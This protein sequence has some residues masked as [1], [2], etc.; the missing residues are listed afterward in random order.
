MIPHNF[1][2]THPP[3]SNP[4]TMGIAPVQQVQSLER[5]RHSLLQVGRYQNE[6]KSAPLYGIGLE[7]GA[8]LPRENGDCKKL[9]MVRFS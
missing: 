4:R 7:I 2:T 3:R 5:A 1:S 9:K 6:G 8:G